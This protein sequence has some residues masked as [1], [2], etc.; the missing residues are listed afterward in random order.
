MYM[1]DHIFTVLPI[2]YLINQDGEPTTPQKLETGTK[3]FVSNPH[4]FFC[5]FV[6]RKASVHVDTKA[7]NMPHQSQ[8]GFC[9]TFVGIP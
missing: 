5:P 9:G 7:I 2:K 8:K 4:V 3:P 1:A 6:V